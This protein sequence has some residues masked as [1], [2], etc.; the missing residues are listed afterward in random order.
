MTSLQRSQSPSTTVSSPSKQQ[1]Q[2]VSS[3]ILTF[4]EPKNEIY[5]ETREHRNPHTLYQRRREPESSQQQRQGQEGFSQVPISPRQQHQQ[6]CGFIAPALQVTGAS[7]SALPL[8]PSRSSP[9]RQ[10]ETAHISSS[11]MVIPVYDNVNIGGDEYLKPENVSEA[12]LTGTGAGLG[13]MTDAEKELAVYSDSED[14]NDNN[15]NNDDDNDTEHSIASSALTASDN[16]TEACASVAS[17]TSTSSSA[18]VS[19][20]DLDVRHGG[21]RRHHQAS[22][23]SSSR[24]TAMGSL[25]SSRND[26]VHDK[27]KRKNIHQDNRRSE[28][29]SVVV[30]NVSPTA[31]TNTDTSTPITA[32]IAGGTGSSGGD[33]GG[34]LLRWE[35]VNE[36]L[37]YVKVDKEPSFSRVTPKVWE[38]EEE[39]E[40][41][42]GNWKGRQEG[43][44]D[45]EKEN[46][47]TAPLHNDSTSS[48][49]Y[50]NDF[51]YNYKSEERPSHERA[52]L[53]SEKDRRTSTPSSLKHLNNDTELHNNK[54][55]YNV[56]NDL[57]ANRQAYESPRGGGTLDLSGMSFEVRVRNKK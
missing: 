10:T 13:V 12:Y 38:E 49:S 57:G 27:G 8:P 53:L 4:E 43:E 40:G 7:S 41:R 32:A 42:G 20:V 47:F 29:K 55:N 37:S 18:S 46:I 21:S 48:A 14:F 6:Q 33:S 11:A 45:R 39:E 52:P 31:N 28:D 19:V 15:S 34:D 5:D 22:S 23:Q 3:E 26:H 1:Q 2:Q 36:S 25:S 54:N 50:N 51:M 16:G 30:S 35:D 56:H 24:H 9:V 17:S 44:K